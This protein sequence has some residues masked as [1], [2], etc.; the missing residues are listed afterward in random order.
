[1]TLGQRLTRYRKDLSIYEVSIKTEI[2]SSV[3]CAFEE[4]IMT[5][6]LAEI[7]RLSYTYGVKS[8]DLLSDSI[9][10]D[11][12]ECRI[13]ME[14]EAA[15]ITDEDKDKI[16]FCKRFIHNLHELKEIDNK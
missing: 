12:M 16:N 9:D 7:E 6:T 2:K 1:M 4:D 11:T 13:K 8:S 14:N 15:V 10:T 5:P 3:L